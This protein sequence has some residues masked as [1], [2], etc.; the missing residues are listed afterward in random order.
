MFP[1]RSAM[2]RWPIPRGSKWSPE[3]TSTSLGVKPSLGRTFTRDEYGDR[4]R[5]FTAVI[6]YRLWQEYF[7]GDRSILGRAVRINRHQVTIVGVAPP[8]FHGDF[9]GV[10][11]DGWIPVPLTGERQRD[12]RHFQAIVRLK[13]GVSLS[14]ANAEVAMVAARLARAFPKTNQGISARIV[15]MWKAENGG[16]TSI[17]ASPLDIL[18]AA[19][20][21]VLLIA[22]AN[23]AN[24]LLARSAAR[25][26][27]F[28]IRTALGA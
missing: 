24:L 19:C 6:S 4:A 23:V 15:P 25:Q 26:N 21:L 27:E 18:G 20:G 3:T 8:E 13:P 1:P 10:A 28:A 22:C 17:L 7:R 12:A 5:A 11:L 9:P 2:E 16:L 14:E